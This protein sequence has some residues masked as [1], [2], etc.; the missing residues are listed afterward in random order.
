M[1]KVITKCCSIKAEIVQNDERE[2]GNRA[3]L[4]LGHTFAHAFEGA[5]SY[6]NIINHG[7]AVLLGM[8]CACEFAN[9]HK[10]LK[11]RD[12][13]KIEQHFNYLKLNK[14]LKKYFSKKDIKKIISFMKTDKKN[15]NEKINLILIKMI[16]F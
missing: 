4:N 10:I 16:L 15:F 11:N 3:L 14:N 8:I 5:K 6:S 1:Q 9:I 7:E 13:K 12:L 2:N